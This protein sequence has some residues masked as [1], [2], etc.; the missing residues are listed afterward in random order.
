M[1]LPNKITFGRI[2][3]IPV[4][5]FVLLSNIKFAREIAFVVFLCAALTDALDGYIARSRN[6]V[7]NLGKFLDPL[8]D[9]L[10]VVSVLTALIELKNISCWIVI[11][12]ICR[13]FIVTGFRLIAAKN[14]IIISASN[15]GKLKTISQMTM[16]GFV[17]LDFKNFYLVMIKY[18]LIY[19][20][21]VL[22]IVSGI[23]YL[24]KNKFAFK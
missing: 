16:T 8:V 19:S 14:N 2:F 13:E 18:V 3:L 6:L 12:I 20:S 24:Y 10:L 11:I 23:D 22:T 1:T 7:S 4:C 15:L 9:K 5:L 21:L 17:M